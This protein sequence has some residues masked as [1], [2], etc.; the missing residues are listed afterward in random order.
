MASISV[1]SIDNGSNHPQSPANEERQL[2]G[3]NSRRFLSQT[4]SFASRCGDEF[5]E[6]LSMSALADL[7]QRL[8]ELET[9][10]AQQSDMITL[11]IKDLYRFC[12]DTSER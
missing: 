7:R 3:G 12:H 8:T 2:P 11:A 5:N 6:Q 1:S 4:P 10:S 9:V